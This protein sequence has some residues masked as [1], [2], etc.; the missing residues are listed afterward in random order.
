[1]SYVKLKLLPIRRRVKMRA[2][3]QHY[4]NKACAEGTE[5]PSTLCIASI[6]ESLVDVGAEFKFIAQRE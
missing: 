1:M 4:E 3:L 5:R 2:A 6:S